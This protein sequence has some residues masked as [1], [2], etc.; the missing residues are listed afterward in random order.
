[1]KFTGQQAIYLQIA[2]Y[3]TGNILE[4]KWHEGD[5]IPSVR[6]LA[7]ELEVNPNTVMRT[8]S[9][10]ESC[11]IIEN[12]R[13]IGFYIAEKAVETAKEMRIKRLFKEDIPRLQQEMKLLGLK[14]EDIARKM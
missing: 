2:D 13:G 8:F 9:H 5:R 4:Q 14:L 3:I 10:L 1:M 6:D 12:Q 7:V 11:G